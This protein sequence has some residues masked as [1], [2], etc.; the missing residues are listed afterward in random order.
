MSDALPIE[1]SKDK[2]VR[3]DFSEIEV[4]EVVEL[5]QTNCIEVE[6]E[7]NKRNTVC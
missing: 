7:K 5:S 2:S 6:N 4:N 3:F 1:D